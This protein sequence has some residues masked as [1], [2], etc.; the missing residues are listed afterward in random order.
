MADLSFERT[1]VFLGETHFVTQYKMSATVKGHRIAC[2]GADV[3]AVADGK[4]ARKDTYLDW[5]AACTAT[6]V[7][8]PLL[9]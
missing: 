8:C 2:D 7:W 6:P 1:Q 4:I 9:A 3:F 5:P